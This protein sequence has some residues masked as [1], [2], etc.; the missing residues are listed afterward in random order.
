MTGP[1]T[2]LPSEIRTT[3]LLLRGAREDDLPAY[4]KW[5]SDT[6]SMNYWSHAAHT[7]IEQSILFLDNMIESP[8]NGILD[9]TVCLVDPAQKDDHLQAQPT[10]IVIGKAGLFDGAEIGFLFDRNYWG[11]GYAYEALTAILK[12]TWALHVWPTISPTPE[13]EIPA[14]SMTGEDAASP[15]KV[16]RIE[17]IKADV[18]PRNAASLRVLKKLG[19]VEVGSALRTYETH[20]GWCDSVYLELRRPRSSRLEETEY[21]E[22]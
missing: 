1:S 4:N 8:W 17:K 7:S 18:D 21:C 12:H 14:D 16:T 10:Y 3:R 19:F 11:K 9:F 20:I 2:L 15:S 6:E 22:T 5:L 13:Q